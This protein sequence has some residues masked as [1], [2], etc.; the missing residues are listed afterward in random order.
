MLLNDVLDRALH[1]PPAESLQ[2]KVN[3]AFLY[4]IRLSQETGIEYQQKEQA[5]RSQVEAAIKEAPNDTIVDFGTYQETPGVV[6]TSD[7]DTYQEIL[8]YAF[9]TLMQNVPSMIIPNVDQEIDEIFTRQ[10][11]NF[12]QASRIK[13]LQPRFTLSFRE[14]AGERATIFSLAP[15]VLLFGTT[16]KANIIETQNVPSIFH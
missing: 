3:R 2:T 14:I 12:N 9:A 8:R 6:S 5:H 10:K 1:E 7:P 13:G 4:R 16:T 15:N 11:N